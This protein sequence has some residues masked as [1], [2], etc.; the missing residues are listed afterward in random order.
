MPRT[1]SQTV[2]LKNKAASLDRLPIELQTKII[3]HLKDIDPKSLLVLARV[4]KSLYYQCIDHIYYEVKLKR[5]NRKQF[6]RGLNSGRFLR[7]GEFKRWY[8]KPHQQPLF[9]QS[10]ILRRL[11]LLD[12]V[13]RII[14]AD[15]PALEKT[16][17]IAISAAIKHSFVSYSLYQDIEPQP[18]FRNLGQGKKG[19]PCMIWKEGAM[20]HFDDLIQDSYLEDWEYAEL[21]DESASEGSNNLARERLDDLYDLSLCQPGTPFCLHLPDSWCHDSQ[22]F[23][24]GIFK[25]NALKTLAMHNVKLCDWRFGKSSGYYTPD[26][27]HLFLLAQGLPKDTYERPLPHREALGKFLSHFSPEDTRCKIHIYNYARKGAESEE[28]VK[29]KVLMVCRR[30]YA[31]KREFSL[32]YGNEE[33][34]EEPSDGCPFR[35]ELVIHFEKAVCKYC[36]CH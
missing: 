19:L 5:S 18:L 23:L 15:G 11:L 12:K 33:A 36:G 30:E 8:K 26:E 22:K 14:I 35:G 27:M 25:R 24:D 2:A 3:T 17:D 34:D 1:R 29:R 10:V 9:G 28:D 21:H 4:S 31:R 13:H 32:L 16:F 7:E 20:D 6:F